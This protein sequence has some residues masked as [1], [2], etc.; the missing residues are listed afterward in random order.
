MVSLGV[1]CFTVTALSGGG[2]AAGAVAAAGGVHGLANSGI[3]VRAG[4]AIAV[5]VTAPKIT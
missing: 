4:G 5:S 1:V 2:T 3:R